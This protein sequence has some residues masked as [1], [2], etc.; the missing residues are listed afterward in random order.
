MS[1]LG[2]ADYASSSDEEDG[3]PTQPPLSAP[4]QQS[5]KVAEEP[6][7]QSESVKSNGKQPAFDTSPE[8]RPEPAAPTV[9]PALGPA[10]GPA[11]MPEH[12]PD[13]MTDL[14]EDDDED[15]QPPTSP[16]TTNRLL[17]RN[18]TM[19]PVPNFDIP[20]S[21]PGTPPA[22]TTAKFTRF[23]ELKKKGVHFN[24]RLHQS[25]ALRNPGLLAKLMDF[26]GISERDQYA[27]A[28][29]EALAVPAEFP[30]WAYADEL[31][32]EHERI[33]R[34]KEEEISKSVREAVDFVP[35]KRAADSDRPEAKRSR[36]D[37][38]APRDAGRYHDRD[39]R[40]RGRR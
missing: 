17:L 9:G 25:A 26:A 39:R 20:P 38:K 32:K 6:E 15:A 29:P 21:P 18:L 12:L 34:R 16:Y 19:P 8:A 35:A 24:Q 13:D 28:L 31:V 30:E 22:A 37:D 4:A 3:T 27:S 7:E 36:F 23:L 1:A 2:L 5:I 11:A 10:A 14:A 33:A 40:D